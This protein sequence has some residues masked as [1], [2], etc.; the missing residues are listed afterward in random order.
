MTWICQTQTATGRS[1]FVFADQAEAEKFAEKVRGQS[2]ANRAVAFEE[3][4]FIEPFGE[5]A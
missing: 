2:G 4:E 5:S 1:S 3:P